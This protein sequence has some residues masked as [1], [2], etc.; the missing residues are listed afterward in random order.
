MSI[1]KTLII[2]SMGLGLVACGEEA[3]TQA[4]AAGDDTVTT[5]G[6]GTG[7]EDAWDSRN[8][9]ARMAR[10]VGTSLEYELSK[11]PK[12]GKA[13]QT[14]W[15]DT[16]WPTYQDS[17]NAR[18]MGKDEFSP[19]EKYDL[20]F[21]GWMP[22]AGFMDLRPYDANDCEA[23]F[24]KEYY[25]SLGPAARYM[26]EN[27]GNKK[28]RDL[29]YRDGS[30][31][32][33]CDEKQGE[34]VESWWGLC[35]AWSPAAIVEPE[36]VHP[37]TKNGV[38]FYAS[39]IK[40]LLITVYDSS[41]SIIL[42]GRCNTKDVERDE[43]GRIKDPACRDTNAGAFHVIMTNFLGVQHKAFLEDRTYNYEVWNQP[44]E[45]FEVTQLEEITKEKAIELVGLTGDEYTYNRDAKKFAEVFA[46]LTYIT[47]SHAMREPALPMIDRYKRRDNYHY[48]LEMDAAGK[49]VGGEWLNGRGSHATWGISDQPDFLWTSVGP[50]TSFSRANPHVSYAKVKELL[51]ESRAVPT[52][53]NSDDK[54]FAREPGAE[55][56]D[57]DPAGVTDT[58][59]IDE[60]V[61]GS[62]VKV[63][64][65]IKHTYIG[66][67]KI[68]LTN[69]TGEDIVLHANEGGSADDINTLVEVG[70]L[71]GVDLKGDWTL[72]V[73]DNARIDTGRVLRWGFIVTE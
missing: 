33:V 5:V 43:N 59:T 35:H 60:T 73:V 62:A 24:D 42:G 18:W 9:P 34:A 19:L 17:T 7:K 27:K 58:L 41:K 10:F 39:D 44:V 31:T 53:G 52:N 8:D 1:R 12:S 63:Q 64:L 51:E 37:V 40:A 14:P 32:P 47:E 23:G 28:A 15:P 67:L 71:V 66:D 70:D 2:G 68:T 48:V 16:Y 49:I 20:A 61:I 25:T 45:S 22:P 56:P 55:I 36:P 54:V 30:E 4:P 11:L 21:N 46:T 13:A 69:G 72:K 26:S 29:V 38:T 3:D 57:N 50:E 65:D 6:K